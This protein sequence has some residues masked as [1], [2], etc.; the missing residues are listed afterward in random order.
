MSS[1]RWCYLPLS[2]DDHAQVPCEFEELLS[3]VDRRLDYEADEG[4][5]R[6]V[7]SRSLAAQEGSICGSYSITT[8]ISS[9]VEGEVAL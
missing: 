9:V 2:D 1:D 7:N 6:P 4:M 3:K 5:D 8:V